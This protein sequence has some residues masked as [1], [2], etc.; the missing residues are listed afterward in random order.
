MRKIY[1]HC[2]NGSVPRVIAHFYPPL[3]SYQNRLLKRLALQ[4]GGLSASVLWDG[5]HPQ[6]SLPPLGRPH[7]LDVL[8][9]LSDLF[10]F[11]V[12]QGLSCG[13][14][15]L[16]CGARDLVVTRNPIQP[17]CIGTAESWPLGHQGSP[18]SQVLSPCAVGS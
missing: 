9:L 1:C 7:L 12:V 2:R 3:V 16:C 14:Q 13:T 6:A 17:P 18:F 8:E 10:L 11:L 5:P 4:H 15:H